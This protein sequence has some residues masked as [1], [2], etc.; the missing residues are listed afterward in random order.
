V[1]RT[2][3]AMIDILDDL[4]IQK[5]SRLKKAVKVIET[6]IEFVKNNQQIKP[7]VMDRAKVTIPLKEGIAELGL[8]G[9]I[10]FAINENLTK[11]KTLRKS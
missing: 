7:S 11:T 6:N 4:D 8:I 3:N 10:K 2:L 5:T 1:E 9:G